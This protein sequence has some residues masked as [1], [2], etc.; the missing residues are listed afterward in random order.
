M[1]AFIPAAELIPN[2][3]EVC[4]CYSCDLQTVCSCIIDTDIAVI[5]LLLLCA[6]YFGFQLSQSDKIMQ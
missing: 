5:I 2:G 3:A 1:I 4:K 6:V